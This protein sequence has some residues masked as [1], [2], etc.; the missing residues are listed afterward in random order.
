[1]GFIS[2]LSKIDTYKVE[3][4]IQSLQGVVPLFI[5]Y[6]KAAAEKD[7]LKRLVPLVSQPAHTAPAAPCPVQI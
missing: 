1:M 7:S 5:A 4:E 6:L 3:N 2:K